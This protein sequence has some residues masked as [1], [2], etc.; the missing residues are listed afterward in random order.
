MAVKVIM[1]RILYSALAL[2][3]AQNIAFAQAATA[4]PATPATA[5]P[6]TPATAPPAATPA[7]APPATPATAPPTTPA[8]TAPP[9][10][11]EAAK[12]AST[13]SPKTVGPSPVVK[14]NG[15]AAFDPRAGLV[16]MP[17]IPLNISDSGFGALGLLAYGSVDVPQLR[18]MLPLQKFNLRIRPGMMIGYMTFS[19]EDNTK[20]G[21]FSLIPIM[22]SVAVYYDLKKEMGGFFLSP[23]FRWSQ[24]LIASSSTIEAKPAIVSQLAAGQAST[25]SGS[26]MGYTTKFDLGI[27]AKHKSNQKIAYF[28]DLGM[29][30]HF[31][32]QSGMFFTISLGGAYH[33]M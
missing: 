19:A 28:L 12:P 3:L 4:P 13:A 32:Q 29:M 20:T 5:P 15:F 11:P 18:T 8:A 21:S 14:K 9:A 30:I 6:A 1:L 10:K 31:E 7:T 25:I 24:G 17:F 2:I 16:Y 23:S 26:Y 33:F 22:L 27:E